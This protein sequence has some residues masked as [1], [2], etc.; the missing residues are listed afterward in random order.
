MHDDVSF[1]VVVLSA[2]GEGDEQLTVW[3]KVEN[4]KKGT[5]II[6]LL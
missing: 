4:R 2:F 5:G 1:F 3:V 6:I